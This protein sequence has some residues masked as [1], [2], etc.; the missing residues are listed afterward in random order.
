MDHCISFQSFLLLNEIENESVEEER[1][2]VIQQIQTDKASRDA[3]SFTYVKSTL[4]TH[5]LKLLEATTEKGASSWLTT[6]PLRNHDLYL[7]KQEFWDAVMAYLISLHT[8]LRSSAVK[9]LNSL[10]RM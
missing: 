8:S 7:N 1:S 6:M 5:K 9:S 3:E 10:C 2:E 4:N